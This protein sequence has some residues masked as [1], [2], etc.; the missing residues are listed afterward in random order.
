MGAACGAR[1]QGDARCERRKKEGSGWR[2]GAAMGA[3]GSSIWWSSPSRRGS[4]GEAGAARRA[5][6]GGVTP[7]GQRTDLPLKPA[8]SGTVE[9]CR[10]DLTAGCSFGG[11]RS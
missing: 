3:S 1:T 7:C 6:G 4:R 8:K 9:T 5:K 10:Y 11:A 2:R